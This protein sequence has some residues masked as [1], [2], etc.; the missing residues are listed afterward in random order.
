MAPRSF[1]SRVASPITIAAV[2]LSGIVVGAAAPAN[3]VETT[4]SGA[5]RI[6]ADYAS[7]DPVKIATD[8][9]TDTIKPVLSYNFND[10]SGTTV[11]DA[12]GNGYNGTW[13]GTSSYG[14]GISGGGA[15]ITHGHNVKLALVSGKTDATG[16]YSFEF[17]IKE[18]SYTG[19]AWIFSN[20]SGGS[21]T[22][23]ALGYYNNSGSNGVLTGCY[24]TTGVH[25]GLGNPPI[26]GAWHQ[27]A[28][29]VDRTA[30]AVTWYVDG[31]VAGTVTN[32]ASN[33]SLSSGLPY[34]LGQNGAV[35]YG[36]DVDAL[37]DDVNFYDQMISPS[38]IAD[39][40]SATNPATH[41]PVTVDGGGHGTGSS[42]PLAPGAGA[43][44][45]LSSSPA[46]GYH[47]NSW[48]PETPSTL[49]IAPLGTFTEPVPGTPVTVK[50]NFAPNTYTVKF[51][52][53]GATEGSTASQKLTYDQSATL[54]A[55][56]FT[57]TG[58]TF[59]GW[60]TSTDFPV[61][62]KDQSSVKNLAPGGSTTLYA[63]WM[64]AGSHFVTVTGDSHVTAKSSVDSTGFAAKGSTVSLSATAATGYTSAWQVV[65]PAGLAIKS[66]GTFTMPTQ[67]VVIK[68]VSAPIRYTVVFDAN[69]A[70][71]SMPPETFTY[72]Q[73][74]AL[75]PNAFTR[76]G[77]GFAGWA[78]TADGQ[79]A[80][81]NGQ[82]LNNLTSTASGTITLYAV[83]R[84]M[85]APGD[86]AA[87]VLS[88]DFNGDLRDGSGGGNTGTWKG[89]P[90]YVMGFDGLAASVS[91]GTN[92]VK[93]PILPGQTDGSSSF[94]YEFW[95]WGQSR[96]S[97]GPIIS[98]QNF[99][100]CT[101]PGVTLFNHVTQGQLE[102]CISA[103]RSVS[104]APALLGWHHVAVV[105]DQ[106]TKAL[107]VYEDGAPVATLATGS[108]NFDS[109]L[110]F[111][112]GG[113]SGSEA[114]T[115][116]GYTNAYI[117][118]LA[119]FN[120]ALPAAQVL[121][122]YDATK[123]SD[124]ALL[125]KVP[126][127]VAYNAGTTVQKG[128]LVDTFHAPQVSAGSKV[129][130]PIAGLWNGAAVTSYTKTS[131]DSWLKVDA[132]GVITGQ[133]PFFRSLDPVEIVVKATDG[134][135][136][137]TI[138]VEFPIIGRSDVPRIQTATWNLSDAGTHSDDALQKDLAVITSNGLD[139]IGVQ[140]DGGQFAT[141]LAKALGWYSYEGGQGLGIVSAFPLSKSGVVN[142]TAT[143]PAVA[144]TADVLGTSIR[145]WNAV[146]DDGSYGPYQACF[147][148]VTSPAALVA[149]EK[150]TTRYAQAVAIASKMK[151]DVKSA[152]RDPVLFMGD[153]S[154]PSGADW[155]AKTIS[156]HCGVGTTVWPATAAVLG[157][158]LADSYRKAN[159]DPV[160]AAGNTWSP[161]VQFHDA[162]N[163]LEPQDRIDYVAYAGQ[164]LKLVG[165]STLV[166][167]WPSVTNVSTSAWASDH[168]AVVSTFTLGVPL[169]AVSVPT[170]T[171]AN[172]A[173]TYAVG[174][175]P[176][177]AQD[178]LRDAGAGTSPGNRSLGGSS[179]L[180]VQSNADYSAP[181]DYTA[182]VTATR[183]GYLSDPVAVLVHVVPN[184]K[185]EFDSKGNSEHKGAVET[186]GV[187]LT[188]A[189]TVVDTGASLN[190]PG[191]I[192]ADLGRVKTSAPGTYPVTLTGTSDDG[193]VTS[194]RAWIT[195]VSPDAPVVTPAVSPS[196][197]DGDNGQYK[198]PPS[199]SATA[200][201]KSGVIK[202][203]QYRQNGAAWKT[204]TGGKFVAPR[205][206]STYEFRI[207]DGLG[208]WSA[209]AAI[210]VS[211]AHEQHR[212]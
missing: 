85:V 6:A 59:V 75:S 80:Y 195:I 166:A 26:V 120:N 58:Y 72:D 43:T 200:T 23:T 61:V 24:G 138:K 198:T 3:A 89:T 8:D 101:N 32:I 88:Y 60:S 25:V 93:L 19:D 175:G 20:Q 134:T 83:W 153:L 67:D 90:A 128:F 179:S 193:F 155:T 173:L 55:N 94:S 205:G 48:A 194:T 98:N 36:N 178:L 184:P 158:G 5:D 167:G 34:V 12:S 1:T 86:T 64:P 186:A 11:K 123:P 15:H 196:T 109:G 126:T 66:D 102:A 110:A 108:T 148:N 171:V 163:N 111:N 176:K 38:Q 41:F 17:W 188:E 125:T 44:V 33:L 69:T 157:T 161:F 35:N 68:A 174:H 39:D 56:G 210:S 95:M 45:T 79:P 136:T 203:F 52:G 103:T 28:A 91:N 124:P 191:T 197:P 78:T 190:V 81:S 168:A 177:N 122:D 49:S 147:Q 165:S 73:P 118:D 2:L 164:N 18:N 121:G 127:G 159:P 117:D 141:Q 65:S 21:C 142:A 211:V 182:L 100:S 112:I 139:V 92:Y 212:G 181:G 47:F 104:I 149:K 82:T 140:E 154:S 132:K 22:D 172:S 209:S 31:N 9:L 192:R 40:F 135:I 37:Y 116:D 208:Y 199:I 170:V 105:V 97:W 107:T 189:Q 71:G 183:S 145:V 10:D 84:K 27:L 16:S 151:G 202:A 30:G 146:L 129:S 42:S 187:T 87:P 13:T 57:R 14:S 150:S 133:A 77:F 206:K 207:K 63:L 137:S 74:T 162:A 119:F 106:A 76:S 204:Y 96:T 99:A 62:Y 156:A 7:V 70:G 152:N 143:A 50:A 130:Q 115:S 54:P 144:V 29:V 201:D 131:G 51:D 114:D 53:N 180:S 46:T 169:P 160:K 113:L 185:I 4:A